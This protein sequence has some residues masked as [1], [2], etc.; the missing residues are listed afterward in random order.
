MPRRKEPR[1]PDAVLDQLLADADP[2]AVFD[3]NGLLD[4]LKKALAERVLNA[5]MDHHLA[6]EE[7]GNRRNGYGRKTGINDTGQ[8]ELA[9]SRDRQARF[10][11]QLIAKYQR[12]FPGFDDKIISMY[13]RG[14]STREI[15]GYLRDLYGIEVSPDLISAVTDAVLEEVAAWQARPLEPVYPLVFFDALRVKIRD[16]GL[17]RNR[18]VHIRSAERR[19]GREGRSRWG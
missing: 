18:A 11:P 12:R 19:V 2:Q 9:G 17:V 15:V 6:G 7:P 5:E 8:I 1:I 4:A 10:D 16:E 14:M 3:P 13:A